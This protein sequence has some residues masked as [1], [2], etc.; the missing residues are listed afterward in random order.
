MLLDFNLAVEKPVDSPEG[1][2]DRAIVGGTLPYMSPEHLDAFNP[3]GMASDRSIDERPD[4]YALGLIFFELLTGEAPFPDPPPGTPLVETLNLMI[5]C[6]RQPPSLRGQAPASSL[7]SRCPGGQVHGVRTE[8]AYAHARDLAEDLR[9]F[10]DNLPMKHCPEPSVRERMGKWA[11]RHPTLCGSTSIALFAMLLLGTLLG[12]FALVY[13]RMQGLSARVR[14]R[15]FD[16]DFTE[17]QFLLNTAG[18]SNEHLRKGIDKAAETLGQ[19]G[20]DLEDPA[21]STGWGRR[22][23][24]E[25][26]AR[27]REQVVEIIMLEARAGVLLSSQG[28]SGDDRRRA[29]A[30]AIAR[31]DHV[32]RTGFA[33]P[34]AFFAERAR[35]HAALGELEQA[36]RDRARSLQIPRS[37]CHDLT[38][39]A[40]TLLSS[41]DHMGAEKALQQALCLDATSFWAWFVMGHCH[42]AQ[43]R[44]LESAGDFGACIARGPGFAWAHFNRGLA[45]AVRGPSARSQVCL[46]ASDRARPLV[47]R[48]ARQSRHDRARARSARRRRARPRPDH[49]AGPRRPG[50][51]LG[52]RRDMVPH[53]PAGGRRTLFRRPARE[54]PPVD[55]RTR[56]PRFH[57]HRHRPVGCA[58]RSEVGTRPEPPPR[59]CPLRHGP[60]RARTDLREACELLDRALESDSHLIDAVQLRAL[61]CA[62]LAEPAALDDVDRLIQSPTPHRLY[63]AACALAVYAEV[64]RDPRFIPRALDL[65]K[66][67]IEAGFP[68]AEAAHDP[69]LTSLH[70]RPSLN[71][72]SLEKPTYD[73][74]RRL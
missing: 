6:R 33:L 47:F 55:R 66:R 3:R 67:A 13:D 11:I 70:V 1:E 34:S 46:H 4:I 12:T 43:G 65:L 36:Q 74:I 71:D 5:A 15:L 17:T 54:E 27:L 35:Y 64:G 63:N 20:A 37:T 73:C 22:L 57:A 10:L 69:D 49:R 16:G 14:Y 41:G 2:I 7:E 56:G 30:C 72:S 9:R 52:T 31:L 42:Y 21:F 29:V 24:S 48:G 40:T 62:R 38:L 18:G 68:P 32:E 44:F 53:G 50:R 23:P 25:E 26:A 60:C 61:V 45:L 59:P 19:L 8:I 58:G 51:A 39:L 28:G